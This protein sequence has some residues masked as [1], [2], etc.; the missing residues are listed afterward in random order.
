M[1]PAYLKCLCT[2]E[3]LVCLHLKHFKS[4]ASWGCAWTSDPVWC[5]SWRVLCIV[6]IWICVIY[7]GVKMQDRGKMSCQLR[8]CTE[9]SGHSCQNCV[10]IPS[11][12]LLT[13]LVITAVTI[14]LIFNFIKYQCY[15]LLQPYWKSEPVVYA[16]K[17]LSVLSLEGSMESSPYRYFLFW[18]WH[19]KPSLRMEGGPVDTSLASSS[20]PHLQPRRNVLRR[21][22]RSQD[23]L[24]TVHCWVLLS[25]TAAT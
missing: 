25:P 17:V 16:K 12:A 20:R 9:G 13:G 23:L 11:N 15:F 10:Q 22:V 3:R 6:S 7:V 19:H 24:L 14:F 1:N 18:T 4:L 2:R 5:W 21:K 8:S